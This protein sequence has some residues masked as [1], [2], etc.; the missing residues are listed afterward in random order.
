MT[1][2]LLLNGNVLRSDPTALDASKHSMLNNTSHCCS[3][4][5][6]SQTS[7]MTEP[8]LLNSIVLRSAPSA[9]AASKHS[10]V[11]CCDGKCEPRRPRSFTGA[12]C[13]AR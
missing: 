2:P 4:F 3:R 12:T 13:S 1:K 6:H 8:L 11:M 5:T 9:L 10:M 7:V